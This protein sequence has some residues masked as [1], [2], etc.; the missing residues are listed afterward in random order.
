MVVRV[1]AGALLLL[2]GTYHPS[3]AASR[4]RDVCRSD[5]KRR[6]ATCVG[7]AKEE[8]VVRVA[9]C[10]AGADRRNCIKAQKKTFADAKKACRSLRASCRACCAAGGSQCAGEEPIFSGTFAVPDRHALDAL[11]LP[12][13]PNGTGFTWLPTPDGALVIDPT[14]RSPVSAAAECAAFVIGCFQAGTRNWAGCFDNAPPC[15]SDTTFLEDGP[16]CCPAACATRYQELRQGGLDGPAAVTRAI[17]DA[18]SC[19]PGLAGRSQP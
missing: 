10:K 15:R 7:N 19:I 5:C 13:G 3:H 6:A 16:T 18:P 9:A 11:P 12:R 4:K 14:R 17:W 8:R 1:V 2:V